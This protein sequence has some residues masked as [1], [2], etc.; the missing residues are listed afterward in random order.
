MSRTTHQARRPGRGL[1]ALLAGALALP[2]AAGSAVATPAAAPPA[3]AAPTPAPAPVPA[4]AAG[5]TA[6]H[7]D[8]N[9]I[10]A[11]GS[12]YSADAAPLVVDDTLYVYTGHD[13]AAEQQAGFEMHDYGVFATTDVGSGDWTHDPLAM[14]PGEVFGWATG[15]AAYAGQV[16][17][18][19]DGRFYWYAPVQWKN[20][21]V[22]N[23][24]AVGV[25][26]ADSPRGPWAD[27][28]GAPLLTWTDVFGTSTQGQEVIDP[29]VFVDNDGQA[30]LYWGSWGVARVVRL[31]ASMTATVGEITTLRG[32]DDFYEAPWVFKRGGTYYLAYDWKRGG[33]D[34]TPSN[35]QACVAYATASSPL[36]P[37]TFQDIILGGTSA[38]TV[39]PSVVEHGDR[40]YLTYHTKD[41]VGGGHFRRAVAIDEVRWDGDRMLPVTPTRADD[42]ALRLSTNLATGAD[43]SASY[44]EQPPMT[45]RALNDGRVTTAMLPPDQW[46]TYR[47]TDSAVPSDWVQYDWP[48][49]VRVGGVGTELHRDGN[50]IR[51]PESW[52]VEYRDADGAWQ[53]VDG[54]TYPTE[55]DVWHTVTFTPVTTTALRATFRGLPEGAAVHSVAVSEL[56]VDAVPATGPAEVPTVWTA[57]GSAPELPAAVRMPFGDAG[58]LWVPVTW[59]PVDPAAYAEP[60]EVTV[61]GRALGQAAGYVTA[62]VVVSP[63]PGPAPGPDTTAP[64]ATATATGTEGDDGWF[65][66]PVT[67]R[68][69]AEDDRDYATTVETR[70]GDGAWT[71]TTGTTHADVRVGAEG[72]TTVQGRATDGAGNV[73]ETVERTV[74]V[75]RTPPVVTAAVDPATRGVTVSVADAL[76][77]PGAVE[78]QLDGSGDWTALTPGEPVPAPDGLPHALAYRASDVAGNLATGTVTIPRDE[79]TA[80]TGNVAPF[81]TPTASSTSPW[82]AVTG[83]NDGGNTPDGSDPALLGAA[84]GTWP[85]VGE[86]WAQLTWD[87]DVTVDRARLW[88]Y[89]N[90]ADE[91]AAGLIAPRSWVLQYLDPDGTTWRDVALADGSAYGRDRDAFVPVAFAPVT[92][93]ALR[94]VAQSWGQ[95]PQQGSTGIRELQVLAADAGPG[96]PTP[97][98]PV[99]PSFEPPVCVDGAATRGVLTVPEVPGVDYTVDGVPTVGARELEPGAVVTVLAAPAEGYAFADGP[100]VVSFA[101]RSDEPDC[102]P[103]TDV[104]VPGEVRVDGDPAVGSPITAVTDGWGPEGVA[105][106]Y[107]WAVDGTDVAGATERVFTP[108]AQDVGAAV[109]VRVTGYGAGLVSASATSQPSTPVAGPELPEVTTRPVH[110]SGAWFTGSTLRA[111]TAPWRPAGTTLTYQWLRDGRP[112]EGATGDTYRLRGADRWHGVSVVVTGTA[113]GHAP[114]SRTSPEVPVLL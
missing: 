73:S 26:V 32:L 107:Q 66:S 18:G 58:S 88:W 93:R 28:V 24:M 51:P 99:A 16:A 39:H 92:T 94:V 76:S 78:Y 111:H 103:D 13:E 15:D 69:R 63:E 61:E 109:T 44:T 71:A 72:A 65:R 75:D 14:D 83:L 56:E 12:Y 97:V 37:W 52:V 3:P 96:T 11:D 50:W 108:G 59:R 38:T 100:G 67:V 31:D 77:G 106:A 5:E 34:C 30:Y 57:P 2:L 79:G 81:A 54:A 20:T 105:L 112:I 62:T 33:S 36:G 21:D 40:W 8:G 82:E 43:A 87:D 17:R 53:P 89:Q 27:A 84:W 23:R 46:G 9:P 22:P 45:L 48:T 80:L 6:F 101:F 19:T 102:G 7:S 85:E 113:P 41:A 86:Q 114:A 25:A 70:T 68:V 49:P 1:A 10:L 104:V 47:G 42:P 60:G 98:T 90:V 95:A 74:R 110:V 55:T 4:P 35:Y 29:H 91:D 64:T